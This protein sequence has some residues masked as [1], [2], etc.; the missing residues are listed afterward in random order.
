MTP[1]K[2]LSNLRSLMSFEELEAQARESG[3]LQRKRL[4]HPVLMLEAMLATVATTGGRLAD[5]LRYLEFQ[6]GVKVNRSSFYKRMNTT[7][8]KFVDDVMNRVISMQVILEHPELQGKLTG[9]RDLWAYD[10]TTV[11]LRRAL[12]GVFAVGEESER[13]A[14]KLHAGLSLRTRAVIRPR[15]TASKVSDPDGIDLGTDLEDVLVLL[16]RGYSRHRLFESITAGGGFYLTRLKTSTNPLI[17]MVAQGRAGDASPTGATLDDALEANLL[18]MDGNV[19][20][21]VELSLEKRAEHQCLAARVVGVQV[22]D[23]EGATEVWWY[24]T[25]LPR[26][27]YSPGMI[28]E[29]YRLRWQ[30]ELLWKTLKGRFRLDDV[31]ALTEHNV[32]VIMESAVLAYF[33]SLGMMHA[34]TTQKEREKLTVGRAALLFPFAVQY[35]ARLAT[36]DDEDEALELA[37]F[38]RDRVLYGATDTNPK[39]TREAKA[40][41]QRALTPPNA[42]K[43]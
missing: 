1:S 13:A 42:L 38:L 27:S 11:S 3:A 29:L 5:G 34:T 20:I 4:L 26:N 6:H 32:R 14:V 8:A 23:E 15:L 17:T 35:L 25:N 43:N 10:S 39:R 28:M 33:L 30:V 24:L 37:A 18:S 36:T 12:A 21:D 40:K 9:L 31:E 2:V 19:D 7:F 22:T 16:D 41:R